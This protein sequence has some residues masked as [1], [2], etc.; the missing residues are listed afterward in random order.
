[1]LRLPKTSLTT[2]QLPSL[3]HHDAFSVSR[4]VCLSGGSILTRSRANPSNLA[5]VFQYLFLPVLLGAGMSNDSSSGV[6]DKLFLLLKLTKENFWKDHNGLPEVEIQR[7]W[8]QRT[9]PWASVLSSSPVHQTQPSLRTPDRRGIAIASSPMVKS[10]TVRPANLPFR[11]LV[12]LTL[13]LRS[14]SR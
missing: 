4:Y 11:T 9:A 2:I 14:P 5:L 10:H 3:P 8:N 1:M 12:M 6:D 13:S 7:L